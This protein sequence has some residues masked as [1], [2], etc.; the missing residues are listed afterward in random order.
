MQKEEGKRGK[1]EEGT[2][3]GQVTGY[4]EQPADAEGGREKGRGDSANDK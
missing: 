1:G 3:R 2:K 4:R